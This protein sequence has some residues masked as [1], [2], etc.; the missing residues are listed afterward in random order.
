MMLN[1]KEINKSNILLYCR[2][3]VDFRELIKR[4]AEEFR[5]RIEMRQIGMRQEAAKL[6]GI[7]LV[8]GSSVA[9]AGWPI[10]TL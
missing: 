3:S 5:I 8:E 9:Q 6:G 10:F 4:L 7:V 2:G 1:I